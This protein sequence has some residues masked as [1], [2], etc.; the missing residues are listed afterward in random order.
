MIS[1]QSQ[2]PCAEGG[3]EPR[4]LCNRWARVSTEEKEGVCVSLCVWCVCVYDCVCDCVCECMCV[5]VPGGLCPSRHVSVHETLCRVSV[6]RF[7]ES[8]HECTCVCLCIL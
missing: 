1:P 3:G 7:Q 6:V 8:L 4:A 5:W 2:P